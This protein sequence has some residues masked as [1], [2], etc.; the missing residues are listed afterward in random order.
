MQRK[1]LNSTQLTLHNESIF[2]STHAHITAN[3]LSPYVFLTNNF[4]H[5]R[6]LYLYTPC[7]P[8]RKFNRAINTIEVSDICM[9]PFFLQ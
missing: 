2:S 3:I 7:S 6:A 5:L 1:N 4:N 8:A 9:I